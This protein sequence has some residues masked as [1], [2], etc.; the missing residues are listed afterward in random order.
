ML[1]NERPDI[2]K[3]L[4]GS[5]TTGPSWK[6]A[7][8]NPPL[9]CFCS[10]S[11][12]ANFEVENLCCKKWNLLMADLENLPSNPVLWT[13]TA[14][15][16]WMFQLLRNHS[17]INKDVLDWMISL[18]YGGSKSLKHTNNRIDWFIHS[19]IHLFMP[20]FKGDTKPAE[21]YN[22]CSMSWDCP[23]ISSQ[24]DMPEIPHLQSILVRY[25]RHLNCLL[26]FC[27]GATL[28]PS[29]MTKLL[30]QSIRESPD[31]F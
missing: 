8:L 1:P 16:N 9:W 11:S 24:Q 25:L 18:L 31:T 28:S 30:T 12:A 4:R 22:L 29:R 19:T 21:R 2:M 26:S 15:I 27:G 13:K 17:E 20:V 6:T 3:G 14:L 23:G 7:S 5:N 10:Y